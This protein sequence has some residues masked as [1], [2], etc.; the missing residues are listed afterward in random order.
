MSVRRAIAVFLIVLFKTLTLFSSNFHEHLF[1]LPFPQQIASEA[2]E[3]FSLPKDQQRLARFFPTIESVRFKLRPFKDPKLPMLSLQMTLKELC[4]ALEGNP[5]ENLQAILTM[6][7]TRE[8]SSK[9]RQ[10]E[11]ELCETMR[12]EILL[13]LS[14]EPFLRIYEAYFKEEPLVNRRVISATATQRFFAQDAKMRSLLQLAQNYGSE[15]VLR[16]SLQRTVLLEKGLNFS[17]DVLPLLKRHAIAGI[18]IVGSLK[19]ME[20][21]YPYTEE[22]MQK[23]LLE[24][25][26]FVSKHHLVLV[27]HMFEA[28]SDG[29]FYTA[30]QRAL[31]AQQSPLYLEVGHIA[32]LTPRWLDVLTSNPAVHILFHVNPTSNALLHGISAAK[33]STLI[34]LISQKGVPVALGSDGR[35][36]LPRSSYQEQIELLP[37]TLS[38]Y[39][40]L[41]LYH[42]LFVSKKL[43]TK[44]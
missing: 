36:I 17:S 10:L 24:L 19:E 28:S 37:A 9:Q 16:V 12:K 18:D 22:Q 39:S 32:E 42:S 4:C 8:D 14:N 40:F 7:T 21:A 34:R 38:P 23:R 31:Q 3:I 41:S 11:Y 13:S 33:L 15:L 20:A 43:Y 30:F 29:P 27:F 1:S 2:D 25:F 44:Q 26:E 5:K 6:H 35:G